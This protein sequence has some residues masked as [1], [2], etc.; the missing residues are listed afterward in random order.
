MKIFLKLFILVAFF[1]NSFGQQKIKTN[2]KPKQILFVCEHGAARSTIASAYFNKISDS[3]KLNY[4]S[5]YR[6][7]DP[8]ATLTAGT[9]KGLMNDNFKI[10]NWKPELVT[11]NDVKDSYKLITFDCSV[12]N[13][14]NSKIITEQWNGI[15]AISKDYVIARNAILEKVKELITKL[16]EEKKTT[17]K[18]KK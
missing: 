1:Q 17:R 9:Q 11:E 16:Q 8:E 12:P 10:D 2:I 4:K 6:G 7:T 18:S 14:N 13:L 15:P 3:L 5:I